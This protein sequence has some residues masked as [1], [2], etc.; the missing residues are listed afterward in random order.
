MIN[1]LL[2]F[3]LERPS[4]PNPPLASLMVFGGLL[5]LKQ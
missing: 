2:G 5:G 3:P 1:A 4:G